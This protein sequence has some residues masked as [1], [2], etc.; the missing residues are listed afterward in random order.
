M[1]LVPLFVL[2]FVLGP[3]LF[4]LLW[5]GAVSSRQMAAVSLVLALT[6][7]FLPVLSDAIWVA[8]VSFLMIWL[9]WVLVT[10]S[11][12][13]A[14]VEFHSERAKAVRA[15]GAVTTTLPWFGYATADLF[16]R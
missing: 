3:A 2:A 14:M 11:A 6:S 9:G 15:L 4:L 12:S 16:L 5:R 8:L 10:A 13:K 7:P 1:N